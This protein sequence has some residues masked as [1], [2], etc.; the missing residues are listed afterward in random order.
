MQHYG[1]LCGV[2]FILR[3]R[4]YTVT[5]EADGEG[6]PISILFEWKYQNQERNSRISLL[7]EP[8]NLGISEVYYFLC[9]VTGRKCR[10]LYTDG[11]TIASR[12]SFEHTYSDRNKTHKV[13]DLERLLRWCDDEPTD[14]N[15]K[16]RYRGKLT[17]YG[18]RLARIE[19]KRPNLTTMLSELDRLMVHP[20]KRGRHTKG[21]GQSTDITAPLFWD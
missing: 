9:P 2:K 4:H 7:R 1:E 5:P 3:N 6:Y 17:P 13:R 8:S 11:M 19:E 12:W 18:E 21:G 15:R 20:V 14:K 10:K 16:K